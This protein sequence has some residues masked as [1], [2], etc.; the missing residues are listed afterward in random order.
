MKKT[1]QETMLKLH[2][3]SPIPFFL[4]VSFLILYMTYHLGGVSFLLSKGGKL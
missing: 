2:S 1:L 3:I 4:F